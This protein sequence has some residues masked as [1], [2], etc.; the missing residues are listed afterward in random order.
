MLYLGSP[1]IN[2]AVFTVTKTSD[3]LDGVCGDDCSLREAVAAA[4]ATPGKHIIYLQAETYTL[5]L[6]PTVSELVEENANLSGDLDVTGTLKIVGQG[7]AA[8]VISGSPEPRDRLFD[9]L[10]GA[11]LTLEKLR[12]T[13]GRS[14]FFGG[15]V[16]N[17]GAAVLREVDVFDNEAFSRVWRGSGDKGF[18]GGIANFGSLSIF[19]STLRDNFPM[20][21]IFTLLSALE[22]PS[23][24][25]AS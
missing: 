12:L 24:T 5:T 3:S 23:T 18:G 16:Q 7:K 21:A 20:A 13:G 8:T 25:P 19:D 17:A 9:V 4:N 15:A 11:S 10:P 1:A 6:E 14:Y 2:A 22:A